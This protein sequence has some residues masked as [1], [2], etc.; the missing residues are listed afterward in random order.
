LTGP[1]VQPRTRTRPFKRRLAVRQ[2][3]VS[4][5]EIHLCSG[6]FAPIERLRD[7]PPD[8]IGLTGGRAGPPN[9][10]AGLRRPRANVIFRSKI[11]T[12]GAGDDR[13]PDVRGQQS[14]GPSFHAGVFRFGAASARLVPRPIPSGFTP[15]VIGGIMG[16]ARPPAKDH[17]RRGAR[18]RLAWL[19][20]VL[21]RLSLQSFDRRTGPMISACP[22]SS[23]ALCARPAA[24]AAPKQPYRNFGGRLF[25]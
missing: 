18:E 11:R 12:N 19:V 21:R 14:R 2:H 5:V 15:E 22:I 7:R 17:L 9:P 16:H 23:P 10:R 13:S 3:E 8:S 25:R 4:T 24:S 6:R 20:R 1:N